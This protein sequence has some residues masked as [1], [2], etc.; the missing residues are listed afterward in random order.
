MS[1]EKLRLIWAIYRKIV[2]LDLNSM[3][4]ST[5]LVQPPVPTNEALKRHSLVFGYLLC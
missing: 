1:A 4:P 2:L 3:H 5:I